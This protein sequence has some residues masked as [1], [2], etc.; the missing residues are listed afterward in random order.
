[1]SLRN[2]SFFALWLSG[3]TILFSLTVSDDAIAAAAS[4]F[5]S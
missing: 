3:A 5:S 1:M 2:D 4:C